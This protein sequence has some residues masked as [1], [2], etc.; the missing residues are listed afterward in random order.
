MPTKLKNISIVPFTPEYIEKT[1]QWVIRPD[2]QRDFLL[3]G[4]PTWEIHDEH[5]R[6]VLQDKTQKVYAILS[7]ETHVGNC[8]FKHL[9]PEIPEGEIWIYIG[10]TSAQHQGIGREATQQLLRVGF[11]QMGLERVCLH[12]ADF[13]QRAIRM[14]QAFG[15]QCTPEPE[16]SG[17]WTGLNCQVRRMELH[18]SSMR[19]V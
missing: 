2:L 15:F 7:Q 10:E 4:V 12:V 1:F 17:E 11:E 13:N 18:A 14:Y 3:R 19:R 8:G 16:Q 5:F 6:H 9:S